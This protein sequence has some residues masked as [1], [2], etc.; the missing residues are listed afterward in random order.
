NNEV[1]IDKN[2]RNFSHGYYTTSI[3]SQSKTVNHVLILQT[4]Q[5]GKA[6]SKEQFYVSASRGKFEISIYT[7]DKDNLLASIQRSSTRISATEFLAPA[8]E[9]NRVQ[10]IK[11]KLQKIGEASR[12]HVTHTRDALINYINTPNLDRHGP[13]RSR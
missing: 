11:E 13:S 6:A 3:A 1:V 2:Y 5:T 7:D 12:S 10:V 8:K 9:K 4:S